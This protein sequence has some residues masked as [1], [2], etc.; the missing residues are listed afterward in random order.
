MAKVAEIEGKARK[1]RIL[2]IINAFLSMVGL[3]LM[4]I[5]VSLSLFIE[6]LERNSLLEQSSIERRCN[7]INKL[8]K[9]RIEGS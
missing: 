9:Q 2:D 4:L 5:D 3:V 1:V 7:C 8:E 6:Y